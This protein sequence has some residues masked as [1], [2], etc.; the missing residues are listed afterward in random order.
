MKK[1]WIILILSSFLINCLSAGQTMEYP[2]TVAH[3]GSV[4]NVAPPVAQARVA[5]NIEN[6]GIVSLWFSDTGNSS[7]PSDSG[8]FRLT[9]EIATNDSIYLHYSV[10]GN[11]SVNLSIKAENPMT[12]DVGGSIGWG[13]YKYDNRN[14]CI[15]GLG[16][17]NYG[18]L[19][20]YAGT[21]NVRLF[22]STV[23]IPSDAT[24]VNGNHHYTSNMEV[25]VEIV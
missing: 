22:V 3:E 4:I 23:N 7:T 10:L 9:G 6:Q 15:S 16:N 13:I 5:W 20:N 18:L 21:G 1:Y 8:P 2:S 17:Y 14:T 24:I 12:S 25:R 19:G 11:I